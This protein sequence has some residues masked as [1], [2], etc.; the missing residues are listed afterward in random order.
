MPVGIASWLFIFEI[1][2][3]SKSLWSIRGRCRGTRALDSSLQP[4]VPPSSHSRLAFPS[5][6]L[7][8]QKND[9]NM[10][11]STV[12]TTLL[13]LG[14]SSVNGQL[15]NSF[16]NCITSGSVPSGTVNI[17]GSSSSD[18]CMVSPPSMVS[19]PTGQKL[20]QL[21]SQCLNTNFRYAYYTAQS[22]NLPGITSGQP[23]CQCS[24][25]QPPISG[26]TRTVDTVGD[27]TCN[28]PTD[29]QAYLLRTSNRFDGCSQGG[30]GKSS[31]SQIYSCAQSLSMI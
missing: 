21:Q 30:G 5:S 20:I 24:N 1:R 4:T 10:K 13:L 22:T 8:L 16:I 12:F 14:A 15:Y 19:R 28:T 29:Y 9:S 23:G 26:F 6:E 27:F 17:A 25:T 11:F 3:V 2:R 18:S 31:P 7:I